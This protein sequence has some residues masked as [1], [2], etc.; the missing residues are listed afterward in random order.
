MPVSHITVTM[1]AL[2]SSCSAR[3]KASMTLVPVEVPAKRPSSRARRLTMAVACSVE[4][5]SMRSAIPYCHSGTTKTG[6]DAIDLMSA[7]LA[8]GEHW[9]FRGLDG[10]DFDLLVVAA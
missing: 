2:G 10:N 4:T 7:W 5:C 1:V 3:R 9:G 6:S 8:T